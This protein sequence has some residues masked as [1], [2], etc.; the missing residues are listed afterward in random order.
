[1]IVTIKRLND[2]L[3][4]VDWATNRDAVTIHVAVPRTEG[5]RIYTNAEQ[6]E[7]ACKKAQDLALDFAESLVGEKCVSIPSAQC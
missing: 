7:L 1:M 2:E 5:Q 4:S 3:F 6:E